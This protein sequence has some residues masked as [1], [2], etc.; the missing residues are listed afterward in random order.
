MAQPMFHSRHQAE[1]LQGCSTRWGRVVKANAG[2]LT[3]E[4]AGELGD[5]SMVGLGWVITT[6]CESRFVAE[7]ALFAEHERTT[8]DLFR[9]A[10]IDPRL[11]RGPMT[12]WSPATDGFHPGRKANHDCVAI[13]QPGSRKEDHIA[14]VGFNVALQFC[15]RQ[16]SIFA[17]RDSPRSSPP[18]AD[19]GLVA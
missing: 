19:L 5:A 2:M 15:Q 4:Q 10:G 7:A 9:P 11:E 16:S 12:S 17:A 14:D 13:N 1:A 18:C 3:E 6:N 8:I